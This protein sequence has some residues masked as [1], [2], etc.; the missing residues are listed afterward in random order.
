MCRQETTV[1]ASLGGGHRC[2]G[3]AFFD[4]CLSIRNRMAASSLIAAKTKK[5]GGSDFLKAARNK[6]DN[7]LLHDGFFLLPS[8]GSFSNYFID[9][10]KIRMTIHSMGTLNIHFTFQYLSLDAPSR[11]KNSPHAKQARR[12]QRS[13]S[14]L[15]SKR[16]L[17]ERLNG[18]WVHPK[19]RSCKG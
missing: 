17:P 14:M 1:F 5:S 8:C 2:V 4:K 18:L 6:H 9:L 16:P 11:Y 15:P 13:F 10:L 19:S 7:G 12:S 3:Q